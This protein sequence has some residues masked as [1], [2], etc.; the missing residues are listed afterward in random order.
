MT[1]KTT[2]RKEIANLLAALLAETRLTNYLLLA[3]CDDATPTDE[4]V[5]KAK[6]EIDERIRNERMSF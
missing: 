1:D 5:E 6:A 4:A 2:D 3:V